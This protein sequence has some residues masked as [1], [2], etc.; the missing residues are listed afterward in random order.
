VGNTHTSSTVTFVFVIVFMHLFCS[1]FHNPTKVLGQCSINERTINQCRPVVLCT[2]LHFSFLGKNNTLWP[3]LHIF[4]LW[5][6]TLN[7]NYKIYY[8]DPKFNITGIGA[9]DKLYW[10]KL[11]SNSKFTGFEVLREV[12]MM[13]FAFW[14]I[15]LCSLL[16]VN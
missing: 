1:L 6:F 11:H 7:K 5:N 14:D 3:A 12:I 4:G 2:T 16:K 15:T 10:N 8:M 13:T 9:N